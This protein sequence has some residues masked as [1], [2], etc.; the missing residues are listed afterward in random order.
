MNSLKNGVAQLQ[1]ARV[2]WLITVVALIALSF[3]G[4]AAEAGSCGSMA[5]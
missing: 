2:I 3:V 1:S 4:G 5:C